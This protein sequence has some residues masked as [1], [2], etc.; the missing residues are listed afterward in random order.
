[1]ASSINMEMLPLLNSSREVQREQDH[2]NICRI[3][4][5]NTGTMI[6]PCLCNGTLKFVHQDCLKEWLKFSRQLYC[7]ICRFKY[8]M[9]KPM[10]IMKL[11]I[12]LK[13]PINFGNLC[14][15]ILGPIIALSLTAA[16]IVVQA[17]NVVVGMS[18][19]FSIIY[20]IIATIATYDTVRP[21]L[22]M[23]DQDEIIKNVSDIVRM[24]S[25]FKLFKR[26]L[27][28]I[29]YW[30]L[31]NIN[32]IIRNKQLLKIYFVISCNTIQKNT[33]RVTTVHMSG[34]G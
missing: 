19:T 16:L 29:W 26:I 4:H 32:V 20:L 14:Y 11:L 13:D 28:R 5:D 30:C 2:A 18:A 24:L 10:S 31:I 15:Y 3:C 1:M 7:N 17:P 9:A 8:K 23:T 34:M 12:Y 22:I 21:H 27:M 33:V 6:A 25:K